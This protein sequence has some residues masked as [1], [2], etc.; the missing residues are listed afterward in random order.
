[1]ATVVWHK[2]MSKRIQLNVK[3]GAFLFTLAAFTMQLFPHYLSEINPAHRSAGDGEMAWCKGE[4]V[5]LT[6]SSSRQWAAR[7]AHMKMER[8]GKNWSATQW[9]DWVGRVGHFEKQRKNLIRHKTIRSQRGQETESFLEMLQRNFLNVNHLLKVFPEW[10][11]DV[12][13]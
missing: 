6:C 8:A 10:A 7:K 3:D 12:E 5:L 9:R 1:M 4:G 11:D 2:S 13:S